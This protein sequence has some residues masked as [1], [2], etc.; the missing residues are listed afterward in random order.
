MF[1][2]R[3]LGFTLVELMVTI[4]VIGVL[5][6]FAIPS[7]NEHVAK[8]R[9]ADA[10][11]ALMEAMSRQERFYTQYISYTDVLVGAGGCAGVACGLN[12]QDTNSPED[13]YQLTVV[14]TPAGCAPGGATPCRGYELK[15]TPVSITDAKCSSLS[16]TN[17]GQEKS[18]GS[19]GASYCWK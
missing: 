16:I 13:F 6:A 9:R 12:L 7:Y 8:A 3:I 4:F 1:S 17:N 11:A 14:A 2:K 10:K 5:A 15:A 18:E 19:G